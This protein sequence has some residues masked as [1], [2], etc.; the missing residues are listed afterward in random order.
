M[1]YVGLNWCI[2]KKY[3][4]MKELNNK[5]I[6]LDDYRLLDKYLVDELRKADIYHRR[7]LSDRQKLFF[8]RYLT[9]T[10]KGRFEKGK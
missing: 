4:F 2:R 1:S 3:K 5:I 9:A 7:W 6:I 10:I 8:R